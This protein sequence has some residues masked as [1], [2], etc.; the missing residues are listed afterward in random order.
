MKTIDT[1]G[2]ALGV[3]SIEF[4]ANYSEYINFN[5]DERLPSWNK[6]MKTGPREKNVK[7]SISLSLMG[8]DVSIETRNKIRNSI[9][10]KN[11]KGVCGFILGHAKEAGQIG[12]K[13]K[14]ENKIKA[15]KINQ[16]KSLETI[17]GSKWMINP[18]SNKRK[19]VPINLTE[20]YIS[21]GYVFGSKGR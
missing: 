1:I 5:I 15:A 21:M 18:E 9:S 13:S 4:I 7:E 16:Q 6:G 2:E 11:K 17:K 8:H 20:T 10:K 3:N 14:S 19:R 12:G